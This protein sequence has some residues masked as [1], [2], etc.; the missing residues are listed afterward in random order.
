MD[1]MPVDVINIILIHLDPPGLLKFACCTKKWSEKAL[2]TLYTGSINDMR[3]RTPELTFLSRLLNSSRQ[4]YDL[5]MG[6]VRHLVLSDVTLPGYR[7]PL[8]P[9]PEYLR[10]IGA[11]LSLYHPPEKEDPVSLAIPFDIPLQ[12]FRSLLNL[13]LTPR[14]KF[15]TMAEDCC[16]FLVSTYDSSALRVSLRPLSLIKLLACTF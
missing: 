9:S 14:L 11:C 2:K 6:F 7:N 5:Y 10:S 3:Y 16:E 8:H 12:D 4:H 13:T 15:I 1:R